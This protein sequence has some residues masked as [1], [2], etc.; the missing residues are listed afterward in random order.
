M[1][2]KM[3][4]LEGVMKTEVISMSPNDTLL[5][6]ARIMSGSH[7]GSIAI[8]EK[9]KFLG[10]LSSKD[11]INKVAKGRDLSKIY[12]HEIIS[13]KKTISLSP[14]NTL[15]EAAKVMVESRISVLPIVEGKKLV[16]IIGEKEILLTAPEL[17]EILSEKLKRSVE[18]VKRWEQTI[19]GLCDS[20]S[21]YSDDLRQVNDEW[22]C[23][24]CRE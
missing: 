21:Q 23:E 14:E 7:V 19:S 10:M 24:E 5:N 15:L 4:K 1:V 6:A 11:I 12:A 17:L 16:G 9:G 13:K 3:V 20:C 2:I 8:I 18:I 22:I